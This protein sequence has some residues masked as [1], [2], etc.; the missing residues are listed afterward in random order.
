MMNGTSILADAR[1][2]GDLAGAA[3]PFII[4]HSS[5]ILGILN[6]P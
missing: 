6:F 5:F 1:T 4:Q 3:P 2:P